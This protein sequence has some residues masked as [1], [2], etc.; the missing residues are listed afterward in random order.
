VTPTSSRVIGIGQRYAGDD[1]VGLAI[2]EELRGRGVPP[3]VELFEVADPTALLPLLETP[4]AVFVVDAVVGAGRAGD[5]VDL[6]AEEIAQALDRPLSTHGLGVVKA[7]ALSRALFGDGGARRVRII[8][9]RI[10]APVRGDRAMS[11]AV[12]GAVARAAQTVLARVAE[13]SPRPRR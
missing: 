4:H 2:L 5:V 6:G 12:S 7:I 3:G 8:G 9:V 13:L 10:E 11:P 1:A